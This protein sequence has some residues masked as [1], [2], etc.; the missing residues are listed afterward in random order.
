MTSP[1]RRTVTGIAG[2]VALALAWLGAS[3][4]ASED[5]PIRLPL[6]GG[7]NFSEQTGETLYAN[8][9]QGCHMADGRGAA[10]AGAYPALSANPRLATARGAV[11]IVLRGRNGMPPL[12][13]MM[14]DAQVA[15]VVNYVR[16]HFG[17]AYGDAI[18]TKDVADLR[19]EGGPS[20]P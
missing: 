17:N 7:T 10:G 9:C 8:A 13:R 19:N 12:G 2:C 11:I 15:A 6:S 18:R 16:S 3:A 14:S 5:R 1:S 4:T 20:E